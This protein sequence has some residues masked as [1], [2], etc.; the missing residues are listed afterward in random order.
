MTEQF[1]WWQTGVVYQIYPRSFQDS[2]ADGIGDLTGITTRLDFLEWLGVDAIWISP[3]FKSPMKDFGYDVS[4]YCDIDPIFGTLADMDRLIEEAH[5]RDIKVILDHVPNHTSDQHPWFIESRSS[6]DNPKRDWYLWKDSKP[7]GSPPNNWLA[8][9]GGIAWEWDETTDQ[10][11]YHAFL[12]E[13]PDLNWRNPE[14][15]AAMSDALRFWL[16]RGVD[17]FR[18][19]VI[20]HM[21]K[22]D[23]WR[24]NPPNPD[25][26][27]GENPYRRLHAVY[28]IDQ[29][30]I[31][32]VV[33]E[34][35]AVVDEYNERVLIG[36]VYLPIDRL[37]AYY[38]EQLDGVHLPFNFALLL[39]RWQAPRIRA[40]IDTYE[41][42]LPPGA[43]PN[44]V[45]GNHDR[46]RVASRVG[47][48]QAP[49]AAMLLLTLRGTPTLYYGDEIGMPNV[50]VPP[51]KV[52]DPPG[53]TLGIG[54]DPERT[55]MQWD[56]SRNAGFTEA[57]E[58]WLPVSANYID[59]NVEA[60]RD[61]AHSILTLHRRLLELRRSSD[62]LQT[63]SYA[64]VET[65]GG[66]DII[67]F[68]RKSDGEGFLIILNLGPDPQALDL[69]PTN[70]GRI[71]LSTHLDREG[72]IVSG[73]A[74][75]RANEGLIMR[76][77]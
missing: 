30:E 65:E 70:T 40:V 31:M 43:W 66:G 12:K 37:M 3:C 19:D 57:A 69:D 8:N 15:R 72:D 33:R 35:R 56:A 50:D 71:A 76:L 73:S 45:L 27:E 23:Q 67:A 13:Q 64:P 14:V 11:Y 42:A 62:A 68:T 44:W 4:D 53:I 6:R 22:D 9:F 20:Y 60:Q 52:V 41:G 36:E 7:D 26:E 59:Q 74:G 47:D 18:V 39:T 16:D 17:G 32:D 58:P 28:S 10:Y 1:A 2:N 63:G 29:P 54:R 77:G 51:D 46:P 25:W 61:D 5:R 55:P 24:D 48:E 38:G 21:I 75:L 49:V 34:M